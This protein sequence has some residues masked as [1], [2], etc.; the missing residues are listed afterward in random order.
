VLCTRSGLVLCS[1][2]DLLLWNFIFTTLCHKVRY[3]NTVLPWE[4]S[5][6][7]TKYSKNLW[8]EKQKHSPHWFLV[9]ALLYF[10]LFFSFMYR[11]TSHPFSPLFDNSLFC[12]RA[13]WSG[14]NAVD[15]CSG[16]LHF[17][18]RVAYW[19]PSLRLLDVALSP[20]GPG[21]FKLW[22]AYHQWYA[23]HYSVAHEHSKKNSKNKK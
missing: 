17:E 18:S 5:W 20:S 8:K 13:G 14:S 4:S 12:D 16:G 22:Y 2:H 19:L 11:R 15:F 6:Q 3:K 1:T 23:S 7:C 10:S 21:L 9:I